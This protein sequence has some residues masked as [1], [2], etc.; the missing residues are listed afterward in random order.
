[1]KPTTSDV[2]IS[3]YEWGQRRHRVRGP[4]EKYVQHSVG[5]GG[6]RYTIGPGRA[7][8]ISTRLCTIAILIAV[9]YPTRVGPDLGL[10][11]LGSCSGASTNKGPQH[12]SLKHFCKE[13]MHL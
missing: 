12:I 2:G 7:S 5:G 11:K 9:V 1:M 13:N 3:Y 10:G 6:G 4:K 8:R